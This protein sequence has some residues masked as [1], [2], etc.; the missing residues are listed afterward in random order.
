[1]TYFTPTDIPAFGMARS[2]TLDANFTAIESA[3]NTIPTETELKQ[4][5]ANY[6]VDSGAA[7][8][9]VV[10]LPYAPTYADGL[11]VVFKATNTNTTASTINV[12][13]L[14]VKNIKRIDG[15]DVL[16]GDIVSG[17][18]FYLRYNSTHFVITPN[19][20]TDATAAAGSAAA[21]AG[22]AGSASSSASAA[23]GSAAAALVSE[24][25]AAAWAGSVNMPS[26]TGHSLQFL[27]ANS[28]E[29]A[30]EY[31][32]VVTTQNWITKTGTYTAV[33]GDRIAADTTGGA[34]TIT[35]PATPT[36]GH[37]VE[38]TDGGGAWATYALTI[39]PNGGT[40]AN[41][42]VDENMT[43]NTN[44]DSFGLVYNGSVWRMF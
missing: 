41:T 32:T 11:E 2:D 9:Y 33:N 25:N 3:F 18:I 14:G 27:R 44:N 43:C 42:G 23:A 16:A 7:N 4:G 36:T 17:S 30:L 15:T 24:N 35:L 21:A 8:A 1:M 40:I 10:A 20:A 28:G 29:T 31:A 39:D 22:S 34:F 19:A 6:A 37:Y 13:S 26:M 38:F 12:N 5:K